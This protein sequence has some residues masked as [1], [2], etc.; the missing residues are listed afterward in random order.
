[1]SL[2]K[3]WRFCR[4]SWSAKNG[5]AMKRAAE[6]NKTPSLAGFLEA[7]TEGERPRFLPTYK[8]DIGNEE[9]SAKK[10]ASGEKQ[11]HKNQEVLSSLVRHLTV[12]PEETF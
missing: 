2:M 7:F 4:L 12:K 10:G 9:G 11:S 1:M 5:A 6:K 8:Y 3:K